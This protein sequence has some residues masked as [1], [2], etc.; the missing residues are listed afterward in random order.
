MYNFCTE[1]AT[2]HIYS[3]TRGG[4][5]GGGAG[6]FCAVRFWSTLKPL[7]AWL[8]L[9]F[10]VF[11]V[12]GGGGGRLKKKNQSKTCDGEDTRTNISIVK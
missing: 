5:G 9:F 12:G 11:L 8:L 10:V 7:I 2:M 3:H 4:G 6:N 1:R